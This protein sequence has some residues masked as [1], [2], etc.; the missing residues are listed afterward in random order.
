MQGILS[1]EHLGSWR[2]TVIQWPISNLTKPFSYNPRQYWTPST[3][4]QAGAIVSLGPDTA[5]CGAVLGPHPATLAG[6][7]AG[8]DTSS[9]QSGAPHPVAALSSALPGAFSHIS[10]VSG[11]LQARVMAGGDASAMRV[12]WGATEGGRDTLEWVRQLIRYTETHPVYV[13][14]SGA[15]LTEL[16]EGEPGKRGIRQQ[17]FPSLHP[18]RREDIRL[19]AHWLSET[20]ASLPASARATAAASCGGSGTGGALDGEALAASALG[21]YGAAF[22]EFRRALAVESRDRAELLDTMWSHFFSLV[23]LRSGLAYEAALAKG[24]HAVAAIDEARYAAAAEAAARAAEIE[25]LKREHEKELAE[26]DAQ[27]KNIAQVCSLCCCHV[28]TTLEPM[29]WRGHARRLLLHRRR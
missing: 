13:P 12:A 25:T 4:P 16:M 10:G 20:L 2:Q 15:A 1:E 6:R 19:L 23:Q 21:V 7:S 17:V 9:S 18:T 5:A 24:R 14:T 3:T 26:K 28:V 27:Q 22:D 29:T 11:P 8:A